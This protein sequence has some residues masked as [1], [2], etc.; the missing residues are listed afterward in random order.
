METVKKKAV[1]VGVILGF[2]ALCLI[3]FGAILKWI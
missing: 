2:D 1:T 3:V